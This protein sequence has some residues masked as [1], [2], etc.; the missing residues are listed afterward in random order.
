MGIQIFASLL[1][2]YNPVGSL[3]GK[4]NVNKKEDIIYLGQGQLPVILFFLTLL[5]GCKL[6]LS[7]YCSMHFGYQALTKCN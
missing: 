3:W 1:L 5:F 4:P 7:N 2:L 6:S